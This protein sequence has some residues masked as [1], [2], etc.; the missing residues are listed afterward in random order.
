MK[1]FM[2]FIS[3]VNFEFQHDLR[4]LIYLNTPSTASQSSSVE[5]KS[6]EDE[7]HGMSLISS[8]V[9]DISLLCSHYC[10][11]KVAERSKNSVSFRIKR[12]ISVLLKCD[13]SVV[14]MDSEVDM[15]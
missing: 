10:H 5:C 7:W 9:S 8:S 4:S 12:Y 2:S 3:Y 11:L 6:G 13:D 1:D 14:D 15:T